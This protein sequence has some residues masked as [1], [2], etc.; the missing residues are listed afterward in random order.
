[1]ND[2]RN[3]Y[4]IPANSKRGMLIL[5]IFKLMDLILFGVGITLSVIL[6]IAMPPASLLE[7]FVVLFPALAT[8]TLVVPIPNYHNMRTLITSMIVFFTSRQKYVWR[9]WCLGDD[10]K[11]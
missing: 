11:E 9:G 1:M 4:L 8:G 3:I 2:N 7:T 5:G 6:L 10:Y